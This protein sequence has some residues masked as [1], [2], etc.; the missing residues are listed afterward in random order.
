[1]WQVALNFAGLTSTLQIDMA[2]CHVIKVH[3][4]HNICEVDFT[5][6]DKVTFIHLI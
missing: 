2:F 1:M 6:F 4:F 3:Y 5:S